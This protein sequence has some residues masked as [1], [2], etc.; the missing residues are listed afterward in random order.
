M[1]AILVDER[2]ATEVE[3]QEIRYQFLEFWKGMEK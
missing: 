1:R 2:R 3:K